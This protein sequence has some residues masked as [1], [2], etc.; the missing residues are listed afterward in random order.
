[1]IA[2]HL[3]ATLLVLLFGCPLV[4]QTER[5]VLWNSLVQRFHEIDWSLMPDREA[6][7]LLLEASLICHEADKPELSVQ[8]LQDAIEIDKQNSQPATVWPLFN[9][10]IKIGQLELAAEIAKSSEH[11]SNNMLD[12]LAVARYKRGDEKA[13][14]DYP[15]EELD[16]Y[17][18]LSL[19]SAYAE[20]GEYDK[21]DEF[22][23]GIESLPSNDPRGV[24]AITY[25]NLAKKF[26]DQGDGERAKKFIDKAMEIGGNLYYTGYAIQ[27]TRR[28]IYGE[29]TTDV[30]QFAKKGAAYREHMGRELVTNFLLELART[31]H[32]TEATN[33][34]RFIDEQDDRSYARRLIAIEQA[35]QGKFEGAIES[36]NSIIDKDMIARTRLEIA[37]QLW[38]V[39][40]T[41]EAMTMVAQVSETI[42]NDEDLQN[43]RQYGYL[44][45][46]YGVM[47]SADDIARI[48]GVADAPVEKAGRLVRAMK[49]V[50]ESLKN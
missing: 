23:S 11:S 19:A 2:R 26:H 34:V 24:G 50:A 48:I 8:Y 41:D 3:L 22:V 29:L 16:F 20:L 14:D 38:R 25:E 40:Q 43:E 17:N 36:V 35:S 49:G 13:L 12:R 7:L 31:G 42:A 5:Q 45:H 9:C 33:L 37:T 4:A 10:A 15:R 1:M 32:F 44:A 47:N 27:V 28:S 46:V 18:A 30:E 39:N 21:L 6:L